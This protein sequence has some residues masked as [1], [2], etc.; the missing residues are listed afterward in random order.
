M[1]PLP[2]LDDVLDALSDGTTADPA[3]AAEALL[4]D[5][6]ELVLDA[7][8]GRPRQAGA[9]HAEGEYILQFRR[10]AEA[11]LYVFTKGILVR[12]Y[13]TPTL[14]RP[15]CDWLQT[16]PPHR[17][18]ALLPREHGKSSI[19]SHGLP[20]HILIQPI[21]ANLYFPGESGADQRILL[22][23]E[24]EGRG[25]DH[26]RV[27][28]SAMEANDVFRAF[29]PH[30]CWT[31]PRRESKKWNDVEVIIPRASEYP[32]PSIRVIGVGG[33]I[34]GAHPTVVIKDDL[35]TLE[36][37]NSTTVMQTAIEWHI[38][39]R[40]LTNRVG[41]LEFIIGTR[42]HAAD[43]YAYVMQHDPSVEW[44]IRAI[45][46]QGAAIYPELF[47]AEKIA[48]L[49][50]EFGVLFPLLYMNSAADPSLVDFAA[51]DL[52]D[53]DI[54]GGAITFQEGPDDLRL[55]ER[56]RRKPDTP[57]DVLRGAPLTSDTF[58]ALRLQARLGGVRM[59][60]R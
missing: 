13:L 19:V 29:W 28:A 27:M 10:E 38:A 11:S 3:S 1:R 32:D 53:Y 56:L 14:H 18:G 25:K 21:E 16:V 44:K 23:T 33:A 43:L 41:T 42:W 37:M 46:E 59:R 17:K 8:T 50:R 5:P 35:T 24:T 6:R 22:A 15:F 36:A 12:D 31:A 52:R 20:L 54:I 48:Q 47:S 40:A 57:S 58:A 51:S 9:D 34:T 55:V 26:L 2:D 60:I 45:V 7:A 4:D 39:S 49:Q 30:R